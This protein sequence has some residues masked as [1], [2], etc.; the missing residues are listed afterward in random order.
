ML[1]CRFLNF[2]RNH[3]ANKCF[4]RLKRNKNGSTK[5]K[6]KI[7][8]AM[9]CLFR[10]FI[11]LSIIVQESWQVRVELIHFFIKITCF[12]EYCFIYKY[13]E[14][15][16]KWDREIKTRFLELKWN[17]SSCIVFFGSDCFLIFA[18]VWSVEWHEYEWLYKHDLIQYVLF[19]SYN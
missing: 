4:F 3:A 2:L 13:K 19:N 8:M 18:A 16:R 9:N 5:I 1:F 14:I 11:I 15:C 17:V 10:V 12:K 7:E 6:F